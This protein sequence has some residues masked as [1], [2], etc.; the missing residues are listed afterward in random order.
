MSSTNV[1]AEVD[2]NDAEVEIK[3]RPAK[4]NKK[5]ANIYFE[6]CQFAFAFT[7]KK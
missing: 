2:L 6:F 5:T 3:T 7:Y 4:M 1:I